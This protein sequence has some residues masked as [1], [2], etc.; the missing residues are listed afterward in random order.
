MFVIFVYIYL[1]TYTFFLPKSAGETLAYLICGGRNEK[2]MRT[3]GEEA[4]C[5]L[6]QQK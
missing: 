6:T 2:R 3:R 4:L 5:I 1:W